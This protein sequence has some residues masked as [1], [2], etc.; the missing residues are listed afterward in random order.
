MTGRLSNR[1]LTDEE[2]DALDPYAPDPCYKPKT[3]HSRP[4]PQRVETDPAEHLRCAKRDEFWLEAAAF[5]VGDSALNGTVCVTYLDALK[6]LNES[7][8]RRDQRRRYHGV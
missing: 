7:T 3:W 1:P 2:L 4:R 6:A 8:P 5:G